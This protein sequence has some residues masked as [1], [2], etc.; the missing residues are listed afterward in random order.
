[1]DLKVPYGARSQ[2]LS[3]PDESFL[4]ILEAQPRPAAVEENALERAVSHP[5]GQEPLVD[6]AAP[7]DPVLVLVNDA[8]RPTP[9]AAMLSSLWDI[10]GG[11]DLDFLVATGTHK[12]PSGEELS[13]I[14]GDLWERV[15]SKVSIHDASDESGLVETGRTDAGTH[16]RLN[17]RVVDASKILVVSSVEAHYFAGY[18]GG[19]KI[20]LPGVAGRETIEQNHRLAM[21]P[22]AQALRLEGNP[23]HRDMDQVIDMLGGGRIFAVLAVQDGEHAIRYVA[24]GDMRE[25][26]QAAA[27]EVD[28]MV[29]VPFRER[30]DIVLAVAEPPLDCNLY[31]AQKSIENGH[32]ALKEGGILILASA[33]AQGTGSTAFLGIMEEKGNPVR[34]LEDSESDYRLGYHKAARLA[35]AASEA[36]LWS[37]TGV[38]DEVATTAFL[39]P[40]KDLQTALN[41]ALEARPG[42][43]VWVLRDAGATVPRQIRPDR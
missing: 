11:W 27:R 28:G 9:T 36:D 14:F 42:G 19:R 26:F 41:K 24:A 35:R 5:L 13:R 43:K 22:E 17:R 2:A 4:G 33:C 31:Q 7:G 23:V 38:E 21:L 32:L 1:M 15:R 10:I 40:Q 12:A 3:I 29:S 37:V 25:A 34:V 18:T 20:L 8:T 30:A 39:K 6:F 16:V